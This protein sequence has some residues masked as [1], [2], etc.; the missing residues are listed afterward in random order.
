MRIVSIPI[1]VNVRCPKEMDFY[2]HHTIY[3]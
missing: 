1:N 3:Y 2:R